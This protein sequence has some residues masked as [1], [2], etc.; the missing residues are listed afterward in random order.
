[1]VAFNIIDPGFGYSSPPRISLFGFED[2]NVEATVSYDAGFIEN[3]R[4]SEVRIVGEADSV[5]ACS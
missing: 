5:L 1:M 4:I 2:L 3:G